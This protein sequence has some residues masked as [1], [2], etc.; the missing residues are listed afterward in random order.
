ME[1]L[2]VVTLKEKVE[3][4]VS[5]LLKL[6]V[7]HPVDIRHV[8]EELKSLSDFQVEKEYAEWE[9]LEIALRDIARKLGLILLPL[10]EVETLSYEKI[11]EILA[12]IQEKIEPLFIQRTETLEALNTKESIFAQ[13]KEYFP[14]PI[15]QRNYLY[16]F[17]EVVIGKIEE[18]N[19]SVLER[20][21]KDIPHVIYPFK[22][23]GAKV[24]ALIIGLRRDRIA[25]DK[26]LKDLSWQ[27]V[28][29]PK[30]PHGLSKEVEEKLTLEI[31]EYKRTIENID[32]E[33]KK[34]ADFSRESLNKSYSF[35]LLK[36]SLLGAKRY[37]CITEKTVLLSGWV[38]QDEKE[39]AIK[40][41]K[42]I[43]PSSC[44]E[45]KSVEET[46]LSKEEIPVRL[47]HGRLFKPFELLI[48]SYGV[49]RYGTVDPTIFVAIS[50]LLMFGA[51]FGDVGHGVV[52]SL[53]SFFLKKSKKES[54]KQ[55]ATLFLYCGISASVF[56]ILY[57]SLFGFEFPSLW[58]KPMHNILNIFKI[59][60]IFGVGIIT[61]GILINIINALR[62]KDYLKAV[63]DK[64]GLIVGIV[65]W[66][67]LG[68]VSKMLISDSSFTRVYLYVFLTALAFLFVKPIVEYFLNRNKENIAVSFMEHVIEILEITIAYL[69]NTISFVRIAAYSLAHASLFLVIF[70]ISNVLR[71]VN[72]G[73][74]SL[75][76]VVFGNMVIIL[77]EGLVA[78]IQSLR[79]NYYEFFS[80][81]FMSG[82]QFYKPLTMESR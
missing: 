70:E 71:T 41:I 24:T 29:Y 74:W 68:L 13:I 62:D 58:I 76:I 43:D 28:E 66:A 49:P 32:K 39:K 22:K 7:F 18:K 64:A 35:I 23:E 78:G 1:L 15:Q 26:A 57:G 31:Q 75:L 17:L 50:F 21:L 6:G 69:A 47:K 27:N 54:V 45:E 51:M 80:K 30:E 37:L 19:I 34:I 79:L 61:L 48:N 82:K 2:N 10:K 20:S 38:P 63:F 40:E 56:G 65:Y 12:R 59:S 9:A 72:G 81:F 4:V 16:S 36:K 3:E 46:T 73:V 25:I 5:S 53:V 14:F 44:V 77:L 60:V 67:A 52:L 55:A 11:K 8:E 42:K 33:I